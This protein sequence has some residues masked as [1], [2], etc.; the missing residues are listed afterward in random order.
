M[1]TLKT[2]RQLK[3]SI[4]AGNPTLGLFVRTPALQVV[5]ALGQSGVDFVVLDAEHAPFDIAALDRCIL[6]GRSVGMPVLVRLGNPLAAN[7]Q[8]VLDMGAAGII[9]PHVGSANAARAAIQACRY[10]NGSR[11]FSGQHRAAGYGAIRG[12]DYRKASDAA[13]IVIAQIEDAQ[14]HA[15]IAEIAGVEELDAV[16]VGRADLAVSMGRDDIDDAAIVAATDSILSAGKITGMTTGIFL[17][18]PQEIGKFRDQGASLFM[19]ATDQSL[20]VGAARSVADEFTSVT[21]Q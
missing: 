13:V 8:Q 2:Q 18:T 7:I 20:L 9:V 14:G 3:E 16:F 11:G 19:I 12:A 10:D 1:N 15:N 5:E 17:P 6:A 21:R 4:R